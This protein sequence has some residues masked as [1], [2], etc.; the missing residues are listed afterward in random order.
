[1]REGTRG[2]PSAENWCFFKPAILLSKAN[3]RKNAKSS[4]TAYTSW[5]ARGYI[6]N[7]SSPTLT[8]TVSSVLSHK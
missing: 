8:A 4:L 3:K 5:E 6:H 7:D 2:I 1:M